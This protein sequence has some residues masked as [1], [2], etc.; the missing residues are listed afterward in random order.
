MST[1]QEKFAQI[2]EA[3][4]VLS[5]NEH[6]A[7]YDKLGEYVFKEGYLEPDGTKVLG[8]VFTEKPF[9]LFER[10]F[11]KPDPWDD[12]LDLDGSDQYGSMFGNAFGGQ[13]QKLPSQPEDI[14]LV[15][16]CTLKEFFNGSQKNVS[17]DRQVIRHDAKT[18]HTVHENFNVTVQPGYTEETK[19][20]FKGKGNEARGH[21]ASN[22]VVK[23]KEVESSEGKFYKRLGDDLVYTHSLTLEKALQNHPISF[24]TLDDRKLT[25]CIDEVIS[26]QTCHLIENEGMPS[27]QNAQFDSFASNKLLTVSQLPKG[28]LFLKFNILFPKEFKTEPRKKIVDALV[29]NA[30][31]TTNQ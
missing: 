10:F 12:H 16:E 19:L 26:P 8:Y 9:D 31:D 17:Y 27:T 28:R 4:D 7:I 20:V 25:V 6:R 14:V 5:K 11:G 18:T 22:L 15:M 2:C 30:K 24:T 3:Y 1:N 21:G 29:Q 13:N 23:F